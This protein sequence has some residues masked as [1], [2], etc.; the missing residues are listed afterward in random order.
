MIHLARKYG[1]D[2]I[3]PCWEKRH[4]YPHSLLTEEDIAC[5]RS[6]GFEVVCWHEERRDELEK[7]VGK[8]FWGITTNDPALL[9]ALLEEREPSS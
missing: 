9:K 5:M 8:G 4:P 7:L 6:E 3:H 1:G 2:M